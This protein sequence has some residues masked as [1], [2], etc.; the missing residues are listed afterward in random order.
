ME[1]IVADAN[2]FVYY[3]LCN[4]LARFLSNQK[5]QIKIANAVFL[6]ITDNARRISREYPRLRK[7]ILDSINNHAS[8]TTLEHVITNQ[9]INNI[10]AMQ[11]F[12][13]LQ[14]SGELDLGEI[15]SIPLSIE[16]NARFLSNDI[17]A[18]D[19]AIQLNRTWESLSCTLTEN[20]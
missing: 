14:D 8:S 18:I 13:E 3:Y 11:V 10:F 6:E 12:Y 2:I 7:V 4:L 20:F 17:D 16:L 1:I 15:E 19:A 9:R 5:Y